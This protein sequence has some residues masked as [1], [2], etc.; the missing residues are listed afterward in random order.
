MKIFSIIKFN[1]HFK[2]SESKVIK[3]TSLY[4]LFFSVF[5]IEF[6]EN[7]FL[8]SKIELKNDFLKNKGNNKYI[9]RKFDINDLY[10]SLC[11]RIWIHHKKG[12]IENNTKLKKTENF[13]LSFKNFLKNKKFKNNRL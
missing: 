9:I 12:E 10:L 4:K 3:R 11:C 6:V 2:Y 7:I 8:R 1:N 5:N 13:F